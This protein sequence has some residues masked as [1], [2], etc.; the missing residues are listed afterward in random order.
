VDKADENSY[1]LNELPHGRFR[2]TLRLHL[3]S[4][5]DVEADHGWGPDAETAQGESPGQR[6]KITS[7]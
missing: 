5:R 2:R 7:R 4:K 1:L 3:P 6:I